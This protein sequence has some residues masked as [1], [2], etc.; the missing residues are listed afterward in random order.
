MR[1]ALVCGAGGFIGGHLV[2]RLKDD[3]YWVRGVDIKEHEFTP[4]SADEFLV[5][6]LRDAGQAQQALAPGEAAGGP[7]DEVYQ[8]AADMGGMGFIHSAECEIMHNSALVNL[9][10]I[11]AAARKPRSNATSLSSSVCVYRD[12]D[13]RRG[14]ADRRTTPIRRSPTT[15]TAGRSSMPSAPQ[16][17]TAAAT[18]S[19]S[20]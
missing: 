1:R 11:A 8:L 7:L 3:G 6:D 15:N 18:A 4:S 9:N 14:R 20:A 13:C 10:V 16:P 19:R 5:L 2:R 12:M 17:P